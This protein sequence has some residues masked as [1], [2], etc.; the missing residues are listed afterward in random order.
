MELVSINSLSCQLYLRLWLVEVYLSA[1][2]TTLVGLTTLE[3]V[4]TS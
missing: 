2:L 3:S 1:D 4:L